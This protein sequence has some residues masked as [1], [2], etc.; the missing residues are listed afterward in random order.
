MIRLAV[1]ISHWRQLP[2]VYSSIHLFPFYY[3]IK[4][5]IEWSHLV[6]GSTN[7]DDRAPH[8]LPLRNH[9]TGSSIFS[10]HRSSSA[11]VVLM[12]LTLSMSKIVAYD[13]KW[14]TEDG[15]LPQLI[16]ISYFLHYSIWYIDDVI[17]VRYNN[18]NFIWSMLSHILLLSFILSY[19]HWDGPWGITCTRRYLDCSWWCKG[20]L[21]CRWSPELASA[22]APCAPS[23]PGTQM[24]DHL[25]SCI[26][27]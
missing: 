4:P 17:Y 23:L 2:S 15:E 11:E 5:F 20:L 24:T 22:I 16:S 9:R 27:M 21:W 1:L 13:D 10:L 25:H 6:S 18:Y 14:M 7:L 26:R 8:F 3:S 12:T 19:L